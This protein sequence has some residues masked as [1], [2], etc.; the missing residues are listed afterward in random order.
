MYRDV[1]GAQVSQPEP[2]EEHGVYTVFVEM[3]GEGAKVELIHPLGDAS[4]IA[5]FL[6]RNPSGGIHH[7]CFEVDAI[8]AA[9]AD[10]RAK[11]IRTLSEHSKIGAHGKPV[12]FLH[13]KDCGGILVELE[14]A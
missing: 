1:L 3:P 7:I 14:E 5:N 4:P 9:M 10:V 11:G 8:D 2:Q 12:V 13:P 6:D